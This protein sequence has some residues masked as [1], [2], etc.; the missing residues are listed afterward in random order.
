MSDTVF[1]KY[2][3]LKKCAYNGEEVIRQVKKRS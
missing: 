3:S 1:T 2:A